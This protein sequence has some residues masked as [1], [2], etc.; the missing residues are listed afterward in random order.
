MSKIQR[1]RLPEDHPAFGGNRIFDVFQYS[2]AVTANGL[3]FVSGQ[4][5]LRPDGSVPQDP[6]EQIRLAFERT[7]AILR[8]LG[9]DFGD[10]VEMVSYHVNLGEHLAAFRDVKE[11]F[12][13]KDFPAWTIIGVAALARP[14]LIVEI[15]VVASAKSGA[16]GQAAQLSTYLRGS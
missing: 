9:L 10:L 16:A 6:K 4:I 15:K 13:R 2:P 14:E 5:G 7:Q 11:Q 12:I 3:A 1:L 8:G